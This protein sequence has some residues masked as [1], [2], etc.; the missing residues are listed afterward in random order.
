MEQPIFTHSVNRRV[1]GRRRDTER[2]RQRRVVRPILIA[3]DMSWPFVASRRIVCML[4][5][6]LYLGAVR[7]FGWLP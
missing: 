6:L 2:G 3:H 4:V 7:V 1:R 5:R